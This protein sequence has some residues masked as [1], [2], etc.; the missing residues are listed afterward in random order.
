M[1]III[2]QPL[3]YIRSLEGL[4]NVYKSGDTRYEG[5]ASFLIH[6]LHSQVY[7]TSPP[8]LYL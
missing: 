7:K 8:T 6:P 2:M 5:V 1:L 4:H 3:C